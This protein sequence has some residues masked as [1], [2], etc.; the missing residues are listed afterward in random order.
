MNGDLEICPGP[1]YVIAV[2]ANMDPAAASR[3]SDFIANRLP[4]E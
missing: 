3:I 2:L 4:K 1:G